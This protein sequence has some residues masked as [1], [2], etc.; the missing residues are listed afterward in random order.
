M[1]LGDS[2][3]EDPAGRNE[4]TRKWRTILGLNILVSTINGNGHPTFSWKPSTQLK[5]EP[6]QHSLLKYLVA[7]LMRDNEIIAAVAHQPNV[8]TFHVN[9][10]GAKLP[11]APLQRS[12]L[13]SG[14]GQ[15]DQG[16]PP[17]TAFTAVA[18]PNT[19]KSRGEE[20][21]CPGNSP[22]NDPHFS[23]VSPDVDCLVVV[24]GKTHIV[25]EDTT[26]WASI[27]KIR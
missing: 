12:G 13:A 15:N 26:L 19:V 2:A 11:E 25:E 7:M 10:M 5:Q 8:S 21:T 4:L 22:E 23:T 17:P 3:E 9:V 1:L 18:N 24:T 27:L 16:T 6:R 20:K 14:M